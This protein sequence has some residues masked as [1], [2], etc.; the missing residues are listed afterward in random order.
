[1]R[2][3]YTAALEV[4]DDFAE[5][6]GFDERVSSGYVGAGRAPGCSTT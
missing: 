2:E 5:R 1:L 3:R 6:A 4:D